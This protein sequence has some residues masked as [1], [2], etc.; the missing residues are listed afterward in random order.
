MMKTIL[1]KIKL[2]G[3]AATQ[4]HAMTK[5]LGNE[6]KKPIL[7]V[8]PKNELLKPENDDHAWFKN[9]EDT[10]D[11]DDLF[12]PPSEPELCIVCNHYEPS[13]PVNDECDICMY[14]GYEYTLEQIKIK[15]GRTYLK[16]EEIWKY[17]HY[18]LENLDENTKHANH[19]DILICPQCLSE[20]SDVER[21]NKF[22]K[23][24]IA[25]ELWRNSTNKYIKYL[26]VRYIINIEE[27]NEEDLMRF[28]RYLD[29]R[30]NEQDADFI[31]E[32]IKDYKVPTLKLEKE[33][34]NEYG[35]PNWWNATDPEWA[36]YLYD[37]EKDEKDEKEEKEDGN[38]ERKG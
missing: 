12:A 26:I 36:D 27:I 3:M 9:F 35:V 11:I 16:E 32:A 8:D 22:K 25:N 1:N 17:C 13:N 24:D 5:F 20:L 37:L 34:K 14:L 15:K 29:S 18:C 2:F 10:C 23:L 19:D 31:Q 38:N 21:I 28:D 30:V 7:I 4:F 33:E 6:S